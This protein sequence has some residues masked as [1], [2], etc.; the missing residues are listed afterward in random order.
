V[1]RQLVERGLPARGASAPLVQA[2]I[3]RDPIDP[4]AQSGTSLEAGALVDE[5][6]EHVLDD[7]FGVGTLRV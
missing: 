1:G 4:A 6:K 5:L 2:E 7:L 3:G